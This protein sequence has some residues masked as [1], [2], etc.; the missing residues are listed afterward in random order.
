MYVNLMKNI[1][2]LE[3]KPEK[4]RSI[5]RDICGKLQIGF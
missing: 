5:E 3:P 1:T 4:E 2:G